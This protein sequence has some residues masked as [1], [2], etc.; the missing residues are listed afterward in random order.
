MER[1]ALRLELLKLVHC[2]S[3]ASGEAVARAKEYEKYVSEAE[4]KP[5]VVVTSSGH[6]SSAKK[7]RQTR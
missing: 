5:P 7:N 4:D 2:H 1:S 3:R 6:G